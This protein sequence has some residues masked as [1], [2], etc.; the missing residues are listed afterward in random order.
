[1]SRAPQRA[2]LNAAPTNARDTG[3]TAGG[4]DP[5]HKFTTKAGGI[6]PPLQI[7]HAL[8]SANLDGVNAAALV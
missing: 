5:P 3:K 8:R 4:I 6:N 2:G 7:H 1:M